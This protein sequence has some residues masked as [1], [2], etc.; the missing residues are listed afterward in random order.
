ML[1]NTGWETSV[2]EQIS[3]LFGMCLFTA[4]NYIGQRFFAFKEKVNDK[5]AA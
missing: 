2:V 3:M 5:K 4:L 1:R